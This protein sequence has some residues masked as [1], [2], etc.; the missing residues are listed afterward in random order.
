M[1][2]ST[3]AADLI[4]EAAFAALQAELGNRTL[5]RV[6]VIQSEPVF[7]TLG[8]DFVGTMRVIIGQHP[9]GDPLSLPRDERHLRAIH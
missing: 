9:F 7:S 8:E 4:T 2:R 1:N 3:E 6:R 5:H